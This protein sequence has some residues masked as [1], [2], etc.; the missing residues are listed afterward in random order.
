MYGRGRWGRREG[1]CWGYI[2]MY[3]G[4]MLSRM[5][6]KRRFRWI[7]EYDGRLVQGLC[8]KGRER[9]SEWMSNVERCC[10]NIIIIILLLYTCNR[11]SIISSGLLQEVVCRGDKIGVSIVW[12]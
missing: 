1:R 8:L 5:G 7:L 11:A 3:N 4:I 2:M 12:F 10:N 9:K 6:W